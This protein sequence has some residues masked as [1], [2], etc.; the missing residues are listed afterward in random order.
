MKQAASLKTRGNSSYQA[1]KF[2]QAIDL[3]TQAIQVSPRPEPV[4]YSNRA[5]CPSR[6]PDTHTHAILIPFAGYMNMSPPQYER[7][8]ADCDDALRQDPN[9]VKALN[10]RAGALESLHR[11]E[12]SL[13]GL[14]LLF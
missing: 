13:R 3:Y 1:R 12:E 7:V 8:V 14:V 6:F 2:E 5:A 11:Y 9:Y 4:F 10:R